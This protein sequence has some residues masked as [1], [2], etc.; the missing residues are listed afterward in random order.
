ML[1]NQNVSAIVCWQQ[2]YRE[3]DLLVQL[4]T[5]RFGF[6]TFLVHGA[7]KRGFKFKQAVMPFALGDYL[8][9][10]N[11]TGL[12]YFTA[13]DNLALLANLRQDISK[14]AY[15]TYLLSLAHAAYGNA[16]LGQFFFQIKHALELIDAGV[17]AAIITNIIEVQ[18]LKPFGV[19]PNWRD[20]VVC[21][22]VQAPLDFSEQLGG[23]LCAKHLYMDAHRFHLDARTLY[24]LR[25]F[26]QYR[27]SN[28]TT[29]KVN[30]TTKKRLRFFLDTLYRDEVGVNLKAKSFLDQMNS[31]DDYLRMQQKK[32]QTPLDKPKKTSYP[33]S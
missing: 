14:T 8:A 30:E 12:S 9:T 5:D 17:D 24:Y 4:L 3:R 23:I 1:T 26:S 29:V 19:E 10:I 33:K 28:K 13:A 31:W 2:N 16:P 18:L 11:E 7:K 27:L 15:A 21:H 22:Q 32:L 6:K 25:L 20:C